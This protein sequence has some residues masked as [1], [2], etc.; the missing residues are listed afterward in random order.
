MARLPR[1][2]KID[3][4]NARLALTARPEPYWA[5]LTAGRF[6][7]YRRGRA[8]AGNWIAR[9]RGVNG[10]QRYHAL[11]PADDL[12]DAVPGGAVLAFA[13]AHRAALAWFRQAEEKD[14]AGD[15]DDEGDAPVSGPFTVTMLMTAYVDAYR[16]SKKRR[17]RGGGASADKMEAVIR[18]SIL[19]DL[20][21]I[22]LDRLTTKHIRA[23]HEALAARP[24]RFRGGHHR[25]GEMTDE[26]R[27]RREATANRVLTILKAALRHAYRAGRVASMDAWTRVQPFHNVE[28][29]RDRFLTDAEIQRLVNATDAGFRSLVLA[30]LL[31]GCRYGELTR[32]KVSDVRDGSIF[33]GQSKSGKARYV[34]LTDEGVQ[35]FQRAIAGK[36]GSDHVFVRPDGKVWG[37]SHQQRPFLRAVQRAKLGNDVTFH[38]LRHSYASKL[39]QR[40][41]SLMTIAVQLGHR[42]TRMVEK[43]YGHLQPSHIR[44]AVQGAM[45]TLGIAADDNVL[46]LRPA[47]RS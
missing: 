10:K 39:V 42:D 27:R 23:W 17:V 9:F 43:V 11:G 46:A 1:G 34:Q 22:P 12:V 47:G 6:L 28:R 3:S 45:G 32:L 30:A 44:D 2:Q 35:F 7:G 15:A 26:D 21:D 41:V 33:I 13:D 16:R 14:R 5:K 18:T 31:T 29:P 8:G 36:A 38:T 25:Q 20:G 19:P 4:R 40:G 24:R 37:D